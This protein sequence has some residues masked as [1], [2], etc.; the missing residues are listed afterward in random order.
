MTTKTLVHT[1]P[2]DW[3]KARESLK[4]RAAL[5]TGLVGEHQVR[6][7]GEPLLRRAGDGSL[8]QPIRIDSKN[9]VTLVHVRDMQGQ[10]VAARIEPTSSGVRAFIPELTEPTHLHVVLPE[11]SVDAVVVEVHPVRH[12]EIH[13]VHHSHLDIGYTDPQGQV[14]AEHVS[15]LDS[16]L[17]L[18]KETDEWESDAQFRWCVESLWSFYEWAENRPAEVVEDF[19]AEVR[20]GRIELTA[21]PFNLNTETC[22][23]DELHELL[24]IAREVKRRY[25]ISIP[26]AM[27]T[28][29]PGSIGGLIDV[30]ASNGVKYLSV[31]H[32]WAGRSVPHLTGGQDVPRLFW[33]ES[34]A[35]RRVLVWVTD[36]PHGLAYMEGPMLGFDTSYEQVEDLLPAYLG[37]LATKPYPFDGHM[38]GFASADVPLHRTPYALDLLHLRVQGHFGDNAPPRRIMSETVRRWNDQ[39]VYPRMRMSTNEDFFTE[40]ERRYGIEVPTF[41]G[42]WNNW[43]ADGMGAGARPVQ[44]VRRAQGL[45]ADAQTISSMAGLLGA[46]GADTDTGDAREVYLDAALFDEHTWGAADPW[47]HGDDHTHTGSGEEQWHWK[48][49]KAIAAHDGARALKDRSTSRLAQ[50][51]CAEAETYGSFYVVNTAGHLRGGA[52]RAFL[53]ESLL[54]L[55]VDIAVQDSRTSKALALVESPQVNPTHREAGRFLDFVVPDVPPLGIVRVD[56]VPSAAPALGPT[57]WTDNVPVLENEFLRVDVDLQTAS[58]RSIVDKTLGVELVNADA[59]FGFNAY[60]YDE[61]GSGSGLN[62]MSGH[63]EANPNLALLGRRTL[64]RPAALVEKG[65]DD[66][67]C[68]LVYETSGRGVERITTTLTL[69]HGSERLD[70]VNRVAKEPTL[71]K[72][73]AYFAFPFNG[74]VPEPVIRYDSSA[75]VA[76]TDLPSVPGGAQHMCAIGRWVTVQ[77]RSHSVSWTTQDSA[78]VQFADISLPYAPFP[79]STPETE[80]ATVYSWFHNN[81]WDTNFPV[82]QGFEMSFHY[83]VA[84]APTS[85]PEQATAVAQKQAL[86]RSQPLVAVLASSSDS[87]GECRTELSLL[88]LSDDRVRLVGLTTPVPGQL[89]VRLQSVADTQVTCAIDLRS[90]VARA[91]LVTYLGD[92]EAEAQVRDGLIQVPVAA[93]STAAC[94]VHLD[95]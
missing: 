27:Q 31:A 34:Q 29:V 30:L 85:T 37:A 72:E 57:T 13:L 19:I 77:A 78:L 75:S 79:T 56:V 42:D 53:P 25:G 17:R 81:M 92:V 43:W 12:W 55:D 8:E 83:S 80:A 89:L 82:Q 86:V 71:S 65:Y 33:W 93:L 2:L 67:R 48:Y 61:L 58:I 7:T 15:Y 73:C 64:A 28:D 38:F 41:T 26:A 3:D 36:T 62:H 46:D 47:T 24:R 20:K 5:F 59:T 70:I 49:H 21:M 18:V 11:L 88:A 6:I 14:L 63:L 4:D 54:P 68:W 84:A 66:V 51:L 87:G 23:T 74:V 39:W 90:P 95:L 9:A 76:G 94:L 52:V 40:A 45:V 91:E 50:V 60:V 35:G 1:T 16:A 10:V 32:N 44:L 22:S 69:E